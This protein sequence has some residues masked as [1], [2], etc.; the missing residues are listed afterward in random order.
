MQ[1]K[2]KTDAIDKKII[3]LL[4]Q[5]GRLANTI[6]ARELGISESTVRSRLNRLINEEVIQVVAVS[7]PLKLGYEAVGILKIGVDVKKIDAVTK[8]LKEIESIWFIVHTTGKS[9]LYAEFVA[10]SIES[11]NDLLYSKIYKIDGIQQA[12]TSLILNFIKRDY[13][14]K[15]AE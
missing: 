14:W 11:F 7:N 3:R 13:N 9:G 12:E 8:A 4:Q 5:D 2:I 10:E 6:I 15:A 1:T